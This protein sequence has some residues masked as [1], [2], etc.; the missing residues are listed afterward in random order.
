MV[1]VLYRQVTSPNGP[2]MSDSMFAIG[3]LE[4]G[5]YS[6]AVKSFEKMFKHIAG[7]FQVI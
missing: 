6:D 4:V 7:D 3:W 1:F 2:A 5:R